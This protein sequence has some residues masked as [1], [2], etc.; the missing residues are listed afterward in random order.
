ME[1]IWE[2]GSWTWGWMEPPLGEI[3]F[4]LLALQVIFVAYSCACACSCGEPLLHPQSYSRADA[5]VCT[6]PD[7]EH[8]LAAIHWSVPATSFLCASTV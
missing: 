3:S 7:A 8:R 6:S 1:T 5:A 2:I 4:V